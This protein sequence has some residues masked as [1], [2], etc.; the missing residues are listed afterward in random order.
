MTAKTCPSCLVERDLDSYSLSPELT[1]HAICDFCLESAPKAPPPT[2]KK[3]GRKPKEATQAPTPLPTP[4][5]EPE[6][7]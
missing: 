1:E 5:P 4:Q 7:P 2:P 3:R 6:T